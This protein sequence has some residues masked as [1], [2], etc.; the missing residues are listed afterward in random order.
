MAFVQKYQSRVLDAGEPV[1]GGNYRRI[2]EAGLPFAALKTLPR[3]VFRFPARARLMANF[4]ANRIALRVL[5]DK[6]CDYGTGLAVLR[7]AALNV[8]Q[9]AVVSEPVRDAP[10]VVPLE[11]GNERRQR[12]GLPPRTTNRLKK[13]I[14]LPVDFEAGM[15]VAVLVT[16]WMRA[17]IE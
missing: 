14:F 12:P 10:L 1:K 8:V 13:H 7:V 6:P 5:M 16:V 4:S 9:K 17:V 11:T 3:V 2:A 15:R